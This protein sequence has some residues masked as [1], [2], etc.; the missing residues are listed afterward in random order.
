MIPEELTI[1]GFYSY[2]NPQTISFTKLFQDK[3]FGIFGK[4]GSGKSSILEAMTLALYG[5]TERLS[6]SEKRNYNIMNLKSNKLKIDFIFRA[7]NKRYKFEVNG[8]RNPKEKEK[9][10]LNY[11]QFKE[12]NGEWSPL[13]DPVEKILGLSYDNFKR[14]VIIPQGKFQEFLTLKPSERTKMMKELFSLHQFD[15]S[16]KAKKHAQEVSGKLAIIEGQLSELG[17]PSKEE[18][19]KLEQDLKELEKEIGI[20]QEKQN[21][22]QKKIKEQENLQTSLQKIAELE[23]QLEDLL[24]ESTKIHSLEKELEEWEVYKNVFLEVYI[25]YS[26][27]RI[28]IQ[29]LENKIGSI[30]KELKEL[31]IEKPKIQAEFEKK[32]KRLKEK[33]KY[34]KKQEE[35]SNL[36]TL[37]SLE[38]EWNKQQEKQKELEAE[39]KYLSDKILDLKKNLISKKE[40][41]NSFREKQKEFTQLLTRKAELSELNRNLKD[42]ES[43]KQEKLKQEEKFSE[44]KHLFEIKLKKLLGDEDPSFRISEYIEKTKQQILHIEEELENF[45]ILSSLKLLS[46]DLKIGDTCPLCGERIQNQQHLEKNLQSQEQ[47]EELKLELNRLKNLQTELQFLQRDYVAETKN[48]VERSSEIQSKIQTLEPKLPKKSELQELQTIEN[49]LKQQEEVQLQIA[50]IEKEISQLEKDIESQEKILN[51]KTEQ[52]VNFQVESSALEGKIQTLKEKIS[53]EVFEKAKNFSI[54]KIEERIKLQSQVLERIPIEYEKIAKQKQDLDK[55]ISSLQS[56]LLEKSKEKEKELHQHVT[57]KQKLENLF[58]IH[59][60]F[61]LERLEQ[62]YNQNIQLDGMRKKISN[63]YEEKKSLENRLTEE[64]DKI[65]SHENQISELPSWKEKLYDIT[66]KLNQCLEK[67]AIFQSHCERLKKSLAR[68]SELEQER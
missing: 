5:E 6:N 12:I 32:E 43:L 57:Q 26:K 11:K 60:N 3:L 52:F 45:K 47:T 41:L 55:K 19:E 50:T 27:T 59:K 4:V 54:R 53:Q 34:S 35:W 15:L 23:I 31:E 20:L 51:Q 1:A 25:N 33:E 14:T 7:N 2:Q 36:K 18:V 65:K 39:K 28:K 62:F 48:H 66:A 13:E 37:L 30:E 49:K 21:E 68:K 44:M 8:K 56:L 40:A 24:K 16:D 38:T 42:Y 64:Q 29:E 17:N 10:T 9:V 46:K 58:T 22:L 61:N 67:K 63:Y